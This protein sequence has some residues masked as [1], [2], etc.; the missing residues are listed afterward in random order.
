MSTD[1][2]EVPVDELA[3]I[4][5]K[6]YGTVL[7]KTHKEYSRSGMINIRS[8]INRH[9]R[10]PPFKKSY[11]LM[12]DRPFM[13]ANLVLTGRLRD[14]KEKG[15]DVSS[16][17][18]AMEK[19]DVEKLFNNYLNTAVGDQLNTEVLLHKVFFDIMYYTGRRGKEGL[20]NLTKESFAVKIGA[21]NKEFI[22][23]TFNEK[24][25][26]NQGDSMSAAANALHNDHHVITAIEGSD[27]CPVES[28]KRYMSVLNPAQKAF[29]QHPSTNKKSFTKEPI[30][31]N[32]LGSLMKEISKAAGL[33]REYTNH[34]IRKTTATGL[35]K[36]GFTLEQIAHVTKH[37]NLDSLKHYVDGPT[38]SDKENYN[39]G[40]FSYG[41]KTPPPQRSIPVATPKKPKLADKSNDMID[42]SQIVPHN[43]NAIAENS[44]QSANSSQVSNSLKSVVTNQVRQAP[45]LFQNAS[46]NNCNFTFNIPQ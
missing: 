25:K 20:R 14:N 44:N 22:E 3:E 32:T 43:V 45:N 4:L 19:Q 21:D 26:K 35:R 18:T 29:F 42:N 11:D 2:E 6:F 23:I 10:S 37:K 5:R 31:K 40:L 39:Q 1:F 24:S 13:Q 17:R 12:N 8:G 38:L 27:L 33:S 9:L 15:L 46:F 16:P 7:T 34:Q 41:Q 30:G 36:S 28:Y